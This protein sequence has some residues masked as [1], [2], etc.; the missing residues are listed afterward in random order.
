MMVQKKIHGLQEV[1]TT[2]KHPQKILIRQ[3]EI[4]LDKKKVGR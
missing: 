4:E 1:L 2:D 3:T